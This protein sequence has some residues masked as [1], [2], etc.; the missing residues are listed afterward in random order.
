MERYNVNGFDIWEFEE[1]G[2]TNTLATTLPTGELQDKSVV[3]TY[4]QTQ[5]RG[6]LGNKWE[7]AP[8]KNISMTVVFRP[9]RVEAGKQ[10][11]VSM[12][13][14]LGC[15]DY[16][17]RWVEGCTVK[18]PNDVYV[19]EKKIVGILIEHSIAGAYI[20]QSLCGIG[21]NVNQQCF[22]SDAPNPVSMFQL[23]GRE[24]PLNE[25]LADLLECINRRYQQ[26][27]NYPLLESDFM[28]SLYRRNGVYDWKDENGMFKASIFGLDEYG[29]LLL[30]DVDGVERVYGFK[31][32][33]FL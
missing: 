28:Q 15:R 9:R 7:S 8:E 26:I 24:L 1:A 19:G 25:V 30:K 4:R 32:V 27:Q 16:L 17:S 11:V 21:L 14:A 5:G 10:F 31:E 13:V 23:L 33:K 18:W 12:V 6:Q 22:L 29:R 3:L 20:G 2:S